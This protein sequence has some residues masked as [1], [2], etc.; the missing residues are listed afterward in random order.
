MLSLFRCLRCVWL[1][2]CDGFS[3]VVAPAPPGFPPFLYLYSSVC[4]SSCDS[5][6]FSLSFPISGYFGAFLLP[7]TP[8]PWPVSSALTLLF[9]GGSGF[10]RLSWGFYAS[11]L[12]PFLLSDPPMLSAASAL[13]LFCLAPT[14]SAAGSSG[15]TSSSAVSAL[16]LVA[17]LL[18]L[19]LLLSFLLCL[20]LLRLL[21]FYSLHVWFQSC[22]PLLLVDPGASGV[23]APDPGA[24]VPPPSV[25]SLALVFDLYGVLSRCSP[26]GCGFFAGSSSSLIS[27][28]GVLTAPS[29]PHRPVFLSWVRRVRSRSWCFSLLSSGL[30]GS[31][32]FPPC[33]TPCSVGTGSSWVL[34]LRL[35]LYS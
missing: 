31:S 27:F 35:L 33:L 28:R 34:R 9:S 8:F 22:C 25:H 16:A 4:D 30:P 23:V 13:P 5:S 29:P 12:H 19:I 2:V 14:V 32:L 3:P 6:F 21:L 1:F 10:P 17:P 7:S 15:F 11:L 26:A 20:V 24:L 18:G